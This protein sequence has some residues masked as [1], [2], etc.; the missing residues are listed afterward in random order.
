MIFS[1]LKLLY[2]KIEIY[3]IKVN[4]QKPKKR[5]TLPKEIFFYSD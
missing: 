4:I 5:N 3:F 2:F 1:T